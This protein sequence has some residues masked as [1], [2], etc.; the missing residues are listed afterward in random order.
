MR[1]NAP[2]FPRN[3]TLETSKLLPLFVIRIVLQTLLVYMR[4][5]SKNFLALLVA[6]FM[7]VSAC[8]NQEEVVRREVE[9]E[10]SKLILERQQTD[11]LYQRTLQ[12]VDEMMSV[13]SALEAEEGIVKTMGPE[14]GE[15]AADF[16]NRMEDI[17]RRMN[18]KTMMIR[19]QAD[20]VQKLKN[21]LAAT[22]QKLAAVSR[23]AD[24]LAGI[25]SEQQ[26][27]IISLRQ[28]LALSR[29]SIDSLKA[30]LAEKDQ[31]ISNKVKELNTAYYIIG[32]RDALMNKGIIDKQGQVLFFGGRI[33][34]KQSFDAREFTKIDI[35]SLRELQIPAA[36]DR[37]SLVSNH[38]ADTFEVVPDGE[39]QSLLRI[40]DEKAFWKNAKYLVI[41]IE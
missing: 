20:E 10:Q 32:E 34:V 17:A 22:E 39:T 33:S 15:S 5:S 23:R 13:L 4:Y 38:D 18:D 37:V 19:R 16:R 24:S 9:T 8:D 36:K 21:K 29:R 35:T 11:S 41:M 28:Q 6:T 3:A 2:F 27:E 25:V 31:I 30:K 1:A 40:R 26:K 14:R 12:Q 7:G